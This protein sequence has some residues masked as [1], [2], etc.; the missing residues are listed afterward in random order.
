MARKGNAGSG[1]GFVVGIGF[2]HGGRDLAAPVV[3]Q[4][5]ELADAL[6]LFAGQIALLTEV[7]AEIEEL[8]G[9]VLEILEELVVALADGAA[10]ALHA[11]VA[12]VREVPEERGPLGRGAAA[13]EA[14]EA[15]AVDVLRGE[16]GG[17][18]HLEDRGIEVRADDRDMADGAGRAAAGPAYEERHADPALIEPALGAAER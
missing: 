9:V 10:G 12:V 5:G 14:G 13:D 6:G 15:H 1:R 8:D 18:D 7:V 2:H 16:R 4:G 17:A 11:V 3:E